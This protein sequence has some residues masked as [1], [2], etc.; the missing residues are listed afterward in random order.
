MGNV[1][2]QH[3]ACVPG[4]WTLHL[5]HSSV[6]HTGQITLD[7]TPSAESTWQYLFRNFILGKLLFS[8]AKQLGCYQGKNINTRVLKSKSTLLLASPN[9]SSACWVFRALCAAGVEA[10]VNPRRTNMA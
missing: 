6:L 9:T 1:Q 3:K 7:N 4:G 10:T 8:T 2:A 5:A